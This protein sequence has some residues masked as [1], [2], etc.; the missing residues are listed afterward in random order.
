MA[1]KPRGSDRH[2]GCTSLTGAFTKSISA[3]SRPN[4]LGLGFKFLPQQR[5]MLKP[6]ATQSCNLQVPGVR[7]E[8]LSGLS[9]C[10]VSELLVNP[11]GGNYPN[12]AKS[13][14]QTCGHQWR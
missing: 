10:P 14:G 12:K 9:Q 4:V 6:K 13:W 3:A 7:C 8:E 2:Q 1:G 5:L 11:S